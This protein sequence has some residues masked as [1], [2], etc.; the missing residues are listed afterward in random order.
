MSSEEIDHG[1]EEQ[2]G[3]LEGTPV[4]QRQE[5]GTSSR[6]LDEDEIL[7]ELDTFEA[8][9]ADLLA[10][11]AKIDAKTLPDVAERGPCRRRWCGCC[12]TPDLPDMLSEN[13]RTMQKLA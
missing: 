2:R 13:R 8:A 1:D 9:A 11:A 10:A 4:K 3:L 6:N 7:L 5:S 12:G